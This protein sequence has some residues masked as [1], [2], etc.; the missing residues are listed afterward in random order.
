VQNLVKV[1]SRNA[2][3][4][5]SWLSWKELPSL[6]YY[7]ALYRNNPEK[8]TEVD[9][10]LYLKQVDPKAKDR[11]MT[12]LSSC[13]KIAG[14]KY[15]LAL[16]LANGH[17]KSREFYSHYDTIKNGVFRD[18][19]KWIEILEKYIKDHGKKAGVI[20]DGQVFWSEVE[21]I[22]DIKISA[23]RTYYSERP[24]LFEKIDNVLFF[25]PTQN[26]LLENMFFRCVELAGGEYALAAAIATDNK[27]KERHLK[28]FER[29]TFKHRDNFKC[30][31][32][33]FERYLNNNQTL[34]EEDA[35][36]A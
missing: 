27:T 5:L 13:L 14:S 23:I 28:N 8:F 31:S 11:I 4:K 36:D 2:D 1:A 34:F 12:L 30:Y 3:S 26:I 25:L 7:K 22:D 10:V 6:Q 35:I 17:R 16:T 9:G 15:A 24:G 19:L 21:E 32:H 29:M 18:K 20:N 33:L